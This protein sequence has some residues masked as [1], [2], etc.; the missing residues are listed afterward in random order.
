[1]IDKE[2]R[3][4]AVKSR[5]LLKKIHILYKEAKS[6]SLSNDKECI[7][8]VFDNIKLS[9]TNITREMVE[10]VERVVKDGKDKHI[11]DNKR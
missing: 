3:L 1:M 4:Y 7:D 6:K 8:W 10:M 11:K 9:N 5:E 2:T